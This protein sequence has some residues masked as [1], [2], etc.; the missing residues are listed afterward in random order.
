MSDSKTDSLKDIIKKHL[1]RVAPEVDLEELDPEADLGSTLDID[2]MDF[3]TMMVAIS[4]ELNVEIPE[5]EYGKL[6]SLK[7]IEEFL[8]E[9][10]E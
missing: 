7:S 4:E 1:H 3:Y 9:S 2:S 5:E 10:V 8:K 6:R